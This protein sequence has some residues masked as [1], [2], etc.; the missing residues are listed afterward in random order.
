MTSHAVLAVLI[1]ASLQ[2]VSSARQDKA[3]TL[4]VDSEGGVDSS[5]RSACSAI[6][7][8][9]TEVM[10]GDSWRLEGADGNKKGT[11]ISWSPKL[12]AAMKSG[13]DQASVAVGAGD[14][15]AGVFA[16]ANIEDV[17]GTNQGAYKEAKAAGTDPVEAMKSELKVDV[18]EGDEGKIGLLTGG[19]YSARTEMA[20]ELNE[21]CSCSKFFPI[22]PADE[23]KFSLESAIDGWANVWNGVGSGEPCPLVVIL[24]GSTDLHAGI[25]TSSVVKKFTVIDYK[26]EPDCYIDGVS[27]SKDETLA[28][29]NSAISEHQMVV[30]GGSTEFKVPQDYIDA[31]AGAGGE[32]IQDRKS[33][34]D[35]FVLKGDAFFILRSTVDGAE[36]TSMDTSKLPHTKVLGLEVESNLAGGGILFLAERG[37]R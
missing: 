7:E 8:K 31:H 16:S 34:D 18:S 12:K 27:A 26:T 1:F 4:T 5:H 19:A 28:A 14:W 11:Y 6:D 32:T 33:G 21:D 9:V 37:Q 23:T 25:V 24:A 35:K 29:I 3:H 36:D 2:M 17:G 10:A 20:A 22:H 13:G 15:P 30:V